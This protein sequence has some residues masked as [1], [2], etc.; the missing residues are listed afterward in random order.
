MR[1]DRGRPARIS[2]PNVRRTGYTYGRQSS[3]QDR[4]ALGYYLAGWA[5]SEIAIRAKRPAPTLTVCQ[6]LRGR[7]RR[8]LWRRVVVLEELLA[9]DRLL[10]YVRKLGEE[11]DHLL[12]I[13]RRTQRR[14]GIR[15]LAVK[16][17]D[18]LLL[19]RKLARPLH[20]RPADFVLG[21]LDVVALSDLGEHEAEAHTSL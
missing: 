17:P 19:P 9:R 7:R 10:G 15:I 4:R 16:I 2:R 18:L 6:A 13:D 14:Q 20:H 5:A 8:G 1:P 11:I 21:D 3:R 12:L